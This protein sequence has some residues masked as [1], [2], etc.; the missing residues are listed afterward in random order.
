[1]HFFTWGCRVWQ[2]HLLQ[3]QDSSALV[4][5]PAPAHSHFTVYRDCPHSVPLFCAVTLLIISHSPD[6]AL[7]GSLGFRRFMCPLSPAVLWYD[8]A[9]LTGACSPGLSPVLMGLVMVP[10]NCDCDFLKNLDKK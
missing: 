1:M 5:H 6:H 4:C 2:H 8:S 3:G 10:D 9:H 7:V